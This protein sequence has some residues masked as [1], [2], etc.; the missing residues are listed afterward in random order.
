MAVD[1]LEQVESRGIDG[2]VTGTATLIGALSRRLRLLQTGFVRSY[3]LYMFA[4]ATIIV[5]ALMLVRM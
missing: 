4:G 1:G 2:T 5:G 3:A